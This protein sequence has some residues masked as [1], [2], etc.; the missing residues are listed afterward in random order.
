LGTFLAKMSARNFPAPVVT[1]CE[2]ATARIAGAA[3]LQCASQL[4]VTAVDLVAGNPGGLVAGVQEPGD[5]TS[6][7][8]RFGGEGGFLRKARCAA[9]VGVGGPRARNVEFPVHCG[10]AALACVD[11]VDGDLGVFDPAGGAGVLALDADRA[12]ALLHVAGLVDDQHRP[13]VVQV[14]HH[15]AAHVVTDGVGIPL[16]PAQQVLHA[17]R[18]GFAGPL[19]DGPAVLARQVGQ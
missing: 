10:V 13:V 16:G 15:V 4:R 5:H 1:S 7:Q 3:F 18:S 8:F 14:L 12:G 19:G 9:A 2:Q 17:V 6:G 11:Q